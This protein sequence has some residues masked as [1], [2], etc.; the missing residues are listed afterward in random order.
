MKGRVEHKGTLAKLKKTWNALDLSG[1]L[2]AVSGLISTVFSA[3]AWLRACSALWEEL[4]LPRVMSDSFRG[5]SALLKPTTWYRGFQSIW[6]WVDPPRLCRWMVRFPVAIIRLTGISI[7]AVM[8][9]SRPVLILCVPLLFIGWLVMGGGGKTDPRLRVAR[10]PLHPPP[11]PAA[12]A[13][14]RLRKV[15]DRDGGSAS[16][17]AELAR[18][19]LEEGRLRDAAREYA[20]AI[21]VDQRSTDAYVGIMDVAASV[22]DVKSSLEIARRAYEIDPDDPEILNRLGASLAGDGQPDEAIKVFERALK[23]RPNNVVILLNIATAHAQLAHWGQADDFCRRAIGV[24]PNDE[25]PVLLRAL[26]KLRSNAGTDAV[27]LLRGVVK[28]HPNSAYANQVLGSAEMD[29]GQNHLAIGSFRKAQ[30]LMPNW[31]MPYLGAG[32]ASLKSQGWA[33]AERSF[34][35]A[36]E[37][38]PESAVGQ[39][40]L[41]GVLESRGK[42][43][44]AIEIYK[45]VLAAHPNLFMPLNNLAYDYAEQ[46]VNLG[47][48]YN[49]ARD[50]ALSCPQDKSAWDTLGWV[51]F[52]MGKAAEAITH[53]E[54][55][56]KLAPSAPVPHYHLAKALAGVG[57]GEDAM[58]EFQQAVSFGLPAPLARDAQLQLVS[59]GR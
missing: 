10:L 11:D 35:K 25:V 19:Y 28:S 12:T 34:R 58:R 52:K 1:I 53:L 26:L 57:R 49:M 41:A 48:A 4:D 5:L 39:L 44:Q 24:A 51:C 27:Q 6:H 17:H 50:A 8:E 38:A 43:E 23:R 20:D 56:V 2:R 9:T 14:A 32:L 18:S 16:L 55:A 46:G 30:S 7:A 54:K 40:G 31:V 13:I 36:L 15:L 47:S 42:S 45:K 22:N 21:G 59:G 37:M 29:I 3:R 33:E